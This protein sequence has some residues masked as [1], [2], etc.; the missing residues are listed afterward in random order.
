MS[1]FLRRGS[2][3]E[4][5]LMRSAPYHPSLA[6]VSYRHTLV[7]D[8]FTWQGESLNGCFSTACVF[9]PLVS[10]SVFSDQAVDDFTSEMVSRPLL[11]QIRRAVTR[12]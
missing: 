9:R 7:Q 1:V 12:A 3:V 5:R 4:C 6:A 8:I 11:A 10:G 2:V